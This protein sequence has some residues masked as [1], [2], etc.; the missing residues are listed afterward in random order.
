MWAAVLSSA[1]PSVLS[2][3][4]VSASPLGQ[5]LSQDGQEPHHSVPRCRPGSDLQLSQWRTDWGMSSTESW[6][7]CC[8]STKE[9]TVIEKVEK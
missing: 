6:T 8:G 1:L 9:R 4:A 3:S 2:P 7:K 5:E